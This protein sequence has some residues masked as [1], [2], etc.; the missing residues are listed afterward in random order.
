MPEA[1]AEGFVTQGA[2][3]SIGIYAVFTL[4]Y[5]C[6][7]QTRWGFI[8][9]NV[10]LLIGVGYLTYF[11][12]RS[13]AAI[14]EHPSLALNKA[15]LFGALVASLLGLATPN[16][17]SADIYSYISPGW[18]QV[19]SHV[20]PYVTLIK[21]TPGY[22]TDPLLTKLWS[23][24]PFPYGFTFAHITRLVCEIG[25]GSLVGS[26]WLFKAVNW[27]AYLAL[28]AVVYFG[29][30]RLNTP[31]PELSLFLYAWSPLI[32]LQSLSNAH[33]D[34]LMSLSVMIGFVLVSTPFCALAI[35]A[36]V[37]GSMVKYV[38]LFSL[39]FLFIYL[40]RNKGWKVAAGSAIAGLATL[41]A[42]AWRYLPDWQQFRLREFGSNFN[43]NRCSIFSTERDILLGVNKILFH[44][45]NDA[46]TQFLP[47]LL[48]GTKLALITAFVVISL[49][50]LVKSLADRNYLNLTK[51]M[52]I[53]VLA[54]TIW[55]CLI[56]AK[57]FC[58]YLIMVLPVAF[59]LP[60]KSEVR[61][62]LLVLSACHLIGLSFIGQSH[63][64]DFT[65]INAA[66][67]IY[68]LSRYLKTR[69]TTIPELNELVAI[70]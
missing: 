68:F 49:S 13:A 21:D 26:Y 32:L 1:S 40:W 24:N 35:P 70:T 51:V 16:F 36:I 9:Q 59:W 20:N 15:T 27:I 42:V 29:G 66:P 25:N 14:E 19:H 18:Q 33:N 67:L 56:N 54:I 41:V 53:S 44:G 64:I 34:I 23:D 45:H 57:F 37:L 38:W 50:V 11:Y 12:F 4:F 6:F 62:L 58:W 63:M 17:H 47:I 7:A 43:Q 31:R 10:I 5:N 46:I 28:G 60:L 8:L 30:K 2:F 39:P 61:K 55:I 3:V 22:G 52:E 65:V 69:S 48:T